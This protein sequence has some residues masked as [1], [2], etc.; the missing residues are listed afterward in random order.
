MRFFLFLTLV[1]LCAAPQA[2]AE[3][4]LMELFPKQRAEHQVTIDQQAA[5][6]QTRG[7]AFVDNIYANH[8]EVPMADPEDLFME[9]GDIEPEEVNVDEVANIIKENG[10]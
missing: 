6:Y 1:T 10:Q 8:G 7:Q 3:E 9:M 4:Q 5:K 2:R